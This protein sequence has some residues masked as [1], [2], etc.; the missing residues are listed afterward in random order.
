MKARSLKSASKSTA[1]IGKH[2]ATA[3]DCT[4]RVQVMVMEDGIAPRPR[5]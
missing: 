4:F 2:P 5:R 1:N 3:Q